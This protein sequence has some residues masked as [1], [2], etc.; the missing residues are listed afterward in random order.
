MDY[1]RRESQV[2][3]VREGVIKIQM[4]HRRPTIY[5]RDWDGNVLWFSGTS[6]GV[7]PDLDPYE[8]LPEEC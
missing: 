4:T 1:G 8:D 2:P 7:L 6:T 5:R 3:G